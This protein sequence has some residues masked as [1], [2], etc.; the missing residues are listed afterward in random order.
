MLL[1]C[2]FA[3]YMFD[4]LPFVVLCRV[5]PQ[6]GVT[7][8]DVL[9][10]QKVMTGTSSP[11]ESILASTAVRSAPQPIF[12]NL[13]YHFW[14]PM[15]STLFLQQFLFATSLDYALCAAVR[16]STTQFR[17][18]GGEYET[19]QLYKQFSMSAAHNSYVGTDLST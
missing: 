15:D 19:F 5:L 14:F 2:A 8:A 4:L 7:S 13:N 3:Y 11:P 12:G 1:F 6:N 10:V 16:F 18:R 9:F 17:S